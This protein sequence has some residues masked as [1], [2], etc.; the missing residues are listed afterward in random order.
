M[1]KRRFTEE[2]IGR[3]L[4]TT[5]SGGGTESDGRMFVFGNYLDEV[6]VMG[7]RFSTSWFDFYYGR[8]H[9]YSPA[10]LY[11]PNGPGPQTV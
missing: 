6:L 1:K 7:C 2:Q 4:R 3:M 11:A 8:D 9:L 10:V 5:V